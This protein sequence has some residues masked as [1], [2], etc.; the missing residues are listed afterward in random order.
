MHC[1]CYFKTRKLEAK[2]IRDCCTFSTVSHWTWTLISQLTM[3]ITICGRTRLWGRCLMRTKSSLWY[4]HFD[5]QPSSLL[6]HR[7]R[8]ISSQRY[9]SISTSGSSTCTQATFLCSR[10]YSRKP[11]NCVGCLSNCFWVP[12]ISTLG[13]SP[14]SLT[15]SNPSS[16][17]CRR[18]SFS[19]HR[20]NGRR[21]SIAI[22]I[23]IRWRLWPS[24]RRV[25]T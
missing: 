16:I 14:N 25:G 22:M 5:H 21:L 10:S 11:S 8:K 18:C 6:P 4:Q 9:R 3:W 17:T 13:R 23:M 1:T 20:W 2:W 15:I 12:E 24:S 7:K 19:R